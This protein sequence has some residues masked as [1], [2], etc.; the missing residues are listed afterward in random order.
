MMLKSHNDYRV[1]P[2]VTKA[3]S[4]G[5]VILEADA[6][7]KPGGFYC[8]HEYKPA[9]L[10]DCRLD[11]YLSRAK[12]EQGGKELYV[13]LELKQWP[14]IFEDRYFSK[15]YSCIREYPSLN[16]LIYG[17]PKLKRD[18]RAR[19]FYDYCRD[20][21]LSVGWWDDFENTHAI[22]SLNLY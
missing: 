21:G 8:S 12:G 4:V 9:C 13:Q 11:D 3:L 2:Y 14:V 19:R 7:S 16:F 15:L 10:C 20:K 17:H 6:W 18:E 22:Q 5:C 1:R